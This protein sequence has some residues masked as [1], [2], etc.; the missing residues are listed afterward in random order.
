MVFFVQFDDGPL[1]QVKNMAKARARA[2][3]L[4]GKPRYRGKTPWLVRAH[5]SPEA[6][7]GWGI[8]R[9]LRLP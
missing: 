6:H 8:R 5:T 4:Q 7:G 9:P 2:A 1:I 3:A